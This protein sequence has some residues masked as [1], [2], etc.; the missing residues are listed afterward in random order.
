M[1]Q[2][3]SKLKHKVRTQYWSNLKNSKS[4]GSLKAS[5]GTSQ[6]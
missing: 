3:I 1:V 4:E 2:V 6:V 5:G